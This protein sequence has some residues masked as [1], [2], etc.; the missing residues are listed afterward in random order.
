MA[1][2]LDLSRVDGFDWDA[3]N[4]QKNWDRHGVAFYECEEVFLQEPVLAPDLEHSAKEPRYFAFGRTVQGR[5]LTVVFTM[6]RNKIRVV[7]AR[8]MDRR[9]RKRYV[10]I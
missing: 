1:D 5:L 3:G 7:S 6:R 4:V 10:Q 9:E 2:L 8:D